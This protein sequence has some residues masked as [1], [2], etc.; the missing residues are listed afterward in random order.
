MMRGTKIY[1]FLILAVSALAQEPGTVLAPPNVMHWCSQHCTTLTW[2]DGHYG[3]P[4]SI[5]TVEKWTRD[6]VIIQ[7]TDYRPYPGKAVLTGKLS[8]Q[9]NS[10]EN[11]T[12]R[13]TYHPCC[14]L[15]TGTF[16]AA[17]D[18]AIDTVP[19]S[20]QERAKLERQ[21][22][23]HPSPQASPQPPV[24]A[25]EQ[26]R[27]TEICT[28]RQIRGAMQLVENEAVK[29]PNGA[30]LSALAGMITGMNASAGSAKILD[31]KDGTDGGRYTSK[32]PGSFVCRGL[33]VRG[34][35]KIDTTHGSDAAS[36][37][38]ADQMKAIM[39][40]HPTFVEWFKVKP[41]GNGSCR[42]TLL[43]SSLQLSKE[44]TR[45]FVYP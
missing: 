8:A 29:D 26:A 21:A 16:K 1:V 30:M 15:S 3:G 20:D 45:E 2:N 5:W 4:D 25:E 13:W 7:R 23:S 6:M 11:G 41:E 35:V 12:I 34:D 14:G 43:P 40:T 42:L 38:T 17:W 27:R 10:I 18:A 32:D 36:E 22:A 9:G 39:S 31:S 33:F 44:Y 37:I 28:S 19:G 24:S